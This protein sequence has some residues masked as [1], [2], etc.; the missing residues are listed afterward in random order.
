MR[1]ITFI[2]LSTLAIS[3]AGQ[4]KTTKSPGKLKNSKP[5]IINITNPERITSPFKTQADE[6]MFW[7]IMNQEVDLEK[8]ELSPSNKIAII[9]MTALSYDVPDIIRVQAFNVLMAKSSQMMDQATKANVE[10]AFD[11]D[12]I[13]H[14][15]TALRLI[16]EYDVD[17]LAILRHV[18]NDG[19][20]ITDFIVK[21]EAKVKK[22][23]DAPPNFKSA[24]PATSPAPNAPPD[25]PSQRF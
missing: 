11:S 4:T 20:R 22:T 16:F 9:L 13:L 6:E 25:V 1:N 3:C 7:K 23:P 12:N 15:V 21:Q 14:R 17:A 19:A 24:P 10:R 18:L 8:I 2:L 5:A